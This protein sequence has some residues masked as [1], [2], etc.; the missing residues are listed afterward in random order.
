MKIAYFSPVSPQKT[1]I[2]D[3][4][5]CELLPYL[6]RHLDIDLFIDK[7]VK[8]DNKFILENFDIYPYTEYERMKESYDI[9]L[10]H[11]GNNRFH[12]YIYRS[13][14]KD[15][16]ITVFHDIYLH[17]FLLSTSI[18][19]GNTG[20]YKEEFGYCYGEE[21]LNIADRAIRTGAYPEFDYPLVKRILDHSSGVICHSDFS[22]QIALKE[23]PDVNITKIHHP[24]TIP[25]EIKDLESQNIQELKESLSI[26]TKMPII[27]SF[28]FISSYKRYHVLL[29]SFKRFLI[30]FPDAALLLVGKD[31]MGIDNQIAGLGLTG[32]VIKTDFVPFTDIVQF[33]AIADFCVN[34]RHPTAGETS[35]SVLR[36]MAANKPVIISD[37]GWF[38]EIPDGCCL[39]V[40]VDSYEEDLLLAYMQ[41]L[42]TNAGMR[43]VIGENAQRWVEREHS[44]EKI[45]EEFY[46]YIRSVVDGDELAMTRVSEALLNLGIDEQDNDL[47]RH[48]SEVIRGIL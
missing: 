44:P 35:G 2:A 46:R 47:L 37:V 13:L 14:I 36:I 19:Q 4:S 9:P 12:D 45:A 23:K 8:P 6:S 22:I 25:R 5:E 28:G 7:N 3:Y 38:S 43:E 26:A 27:V 48:V 42:T 10:Y 32:S 18:D 29:K 17:G 30:D 24:L 31:L 34:L 33:L 40:P 1:G 21:G 15:P 39:K 20:R 16:G 11:M 41:V